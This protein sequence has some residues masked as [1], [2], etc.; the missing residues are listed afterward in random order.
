MSSLKAAWFLDAVLRA[1]SNSVAL[2]S[3]STTT[4]AD[5]SRARCSVT[6]LKLS[7]FAWFCAILSSVLRRCSSTTFADVQGEAGVTEAAEDPS[8]RRLM[9]LGPL[10]PGPPTAHRFLLMSSVEKIKSGFPA[11]NIP[12]D[13]SR[14]DNCDFG[15]DRLLAPLSCA[16]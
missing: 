1:T 10:E 6:C 11:K 14:F 9:I 12:V 13:N 7:S 5:L 2:A 16:G 8:T 3:G 4:D 15:T